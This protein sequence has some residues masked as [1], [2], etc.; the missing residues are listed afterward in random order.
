MVEPT[1]REN[2]S[3]RDFVAL[4]AAGLAGLGLVGCAPKEGATGGASDTSALAGNL[5]S[6][7]DRET[8]VLVIGFGGGGG[9]AAIEAFDNGAEVLLIE[10]SDTPGGASSINAGVIQAA[11]SSVQKAAGI[12]DSPEKWLECL[13]IEIGNGFNEDHMKALTAGGAANIDWLIELGAEI[14]AEIHESDTHSIPASG[15]YTSDAS[16]DYFPNDSPTPRGHVVVENGQGFYKALQAGIDARGIEVMLG[17]PAKQL[18]Q[19]AQGRI[20][21]A[22]VESEGKQLH[23]KANKGVVVATGHF[24]CNEDM[25]KTYI[26]QALELP[27]GMSRIPMNPASITNGDGQRMCAKV[28]AALAGMADGTFTINMTTETGI[29]SILVNKFCQR[30]WSEQ[31][32]HMSYRGTQLMQEPGQIGFFIFDERIRSQV[33]ELKAEDIAIKADSIEGLADVCGLSPV[34]LAGAIAQYNG[35]C[36]TQSDPDFNKPVKFLEPI[37]DAPYYAVAA[38]YHWMTTGGMPIDVNGRV[39]DVENKIIAGLYAAGMCAHGSY[40]KVNPGSGLNMAWNFYTG[41]L[42][43]KNAAA[44]TV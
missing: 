12:N 29:R 38:T 1:T 14:P 44:E 34:A 7:F 5:P 13:K 43:G 11:G 8:D 31:G 23:I 6:T 4:S 42:A 10:G 18:Y 27:D 33:D 36:A 21:G 22:L 40:G 20:V 41:R 2:V 37:K 35:Y 30:F 39:L 9:A 16:A 26:P 25:V 17:T 19:N 3:R 24:S 28:G 15:L 32:Y